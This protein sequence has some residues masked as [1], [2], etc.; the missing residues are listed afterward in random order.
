MQCENLLK[1]ETV[2]FQSIYEKFN[3][4][5]ATHLQALRGIFTNA[6]FLSRIRPVCNPHNIWNIVFLA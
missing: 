6:N 3:N 4:E 2:K 5:K 1:N